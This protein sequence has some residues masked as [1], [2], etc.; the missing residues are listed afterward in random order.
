M[1]IENHWVIITNA[2]Y[3]MHFAYLFPNCWNSEKLKLKLPNLVFIWRILEAKS[4]FHTKNPTRNAL[5]DYPTINFNPD[6]QTLNNLVFTLHATYG[7][8]HT[9]GLKIISLIH[10]LWISIKWNKSCDNI[11]KYYL[12]KISQIIQSTNSNNFICHQKIK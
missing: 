8:H 10:P 3:K 7:S 1:K 6:S 9:H 5:F 2:Q 12:F 4:E 11:R